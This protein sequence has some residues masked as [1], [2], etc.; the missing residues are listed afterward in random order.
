V[1]NPLPYGDNTTAPDS[2]GGAIVGTG[3]FL[4]EA[5]KWSRLSELIRAGTHIIRTRA[6]TMGT[7]SPSSA[8][9]LLP[10]STDDKRSKDRRGDLDEE[11]NLRRRWEL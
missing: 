11:T 3:L 9:S 4:M 10:F 5:R 6:H 7:V 2:I 1:L 8:G